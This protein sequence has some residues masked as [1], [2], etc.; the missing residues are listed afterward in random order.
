MERNRLTFGLMSE[1]QVRLAILRD[2]ETLRRLISEQ[3]QLERYLWS[4]VR[5]T[6]QELGLNANNTLI[7]H[8]YP[9]A[10]YHSS[11]T[12]SSNNVTSR[13]SDLTLKLVDCIQSAR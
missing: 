4:Y 9:T 13:T 12:D 8:S 3:R 11:T 10:F 2:Q 1:S 7:D 6:M 5:Q